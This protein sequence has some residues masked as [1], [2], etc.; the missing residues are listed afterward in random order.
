MTKI[1]KYRDLDVYKKAFK[2]AM[3]I[4]NISKSFPDEEKYSL[5]NQMRRSSRSVCANLAEAWRKRKYIAAFKNKLTDSMME[6]AETQ[7][8]LEFCLACNFIEQSTFESMDKEY[9][10]ILKM[11]NSMEKNAEKFCY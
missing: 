8:W 7:T 2:S 5:T 4:Y 11:L 1:K 10:D 6:A 9:E 3:Q